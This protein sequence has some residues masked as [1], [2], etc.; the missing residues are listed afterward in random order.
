MSSASI[1]E[2]STKNCTPATATSSDAS[3]ETVIGPDTVVPA[4]GAVIATTGTVV[5]A[6]AVA[7]A[8][9][10]APLKLPAPSSAV[11]R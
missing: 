8:R 6:V 7:D 10:D 3:A 4:A 5:S 2:P 11:T 9:L 1:G